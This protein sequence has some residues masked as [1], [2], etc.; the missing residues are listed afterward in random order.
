MVGRPSITWHQNGVLVM[1]HT[2]FTGK[3]KNERK[4]RSGKFQHKRREFGGVKDNILDNL[5]GEGQLM[6]DANAHTK[7]KIKTLT[8]KDLQ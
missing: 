3:N 6:N 8:W 5:V 4:M 1:G 7:N 2:N